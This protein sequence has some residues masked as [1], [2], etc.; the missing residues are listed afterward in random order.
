MVRAKPYDSECGRVNVSLT[1]FLNSNVNQRF[2]RPN[3][4]CFGNGMKIA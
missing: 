3:W 4:E 1:E 2:G